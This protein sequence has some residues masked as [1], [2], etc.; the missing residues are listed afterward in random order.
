MRILRI[1]L[2]GQLRS[3]NP[4][5]RLDSEEVRG[6][7]YH[8]MDGLIPDLSELSRKR[9]ASYFPADYSVYVRMTVQPDVD[10]VK[11]LI[12]VD[13]PTI[14]WPAG[15]LARR[16]WRLSVPVLSHALIETFEQ[17]IQG[18]SMQIERSSARIT[19]LAPMRFWSD[20]IVLTLS[21]FALT[22]ILWLYLMPLLLPKL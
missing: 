15:L 5:V 21:V 14:S 2:R 19:S 18:V 17:R 6:Q 20:P 12:W 13:D 1:E 10:A 7:F 16:A 22:T 4:N 9:I 8:E 11:I 3:T